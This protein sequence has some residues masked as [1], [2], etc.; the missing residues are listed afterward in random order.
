MTSP[1]PPEPNPATAVP[2]PCCGEPIDPAGI[3]FMREEGVPLQLLSIDLSALPA[4][5][6]GTG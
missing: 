5:D 4:D 3:E 2:C 6:L 1:L